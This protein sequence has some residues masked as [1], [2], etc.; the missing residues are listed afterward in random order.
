[1]SLSSKGFQEPT[2][3]V[4]P[5]TSPRSEGLNKSQVADAQVIEFSVIVPT[6]NE[7]GNI[8]ELVRLLHAALDGF[9]WE[10]VFVDDDSP[11]KTAE[12]VKAIGQGD[13]HVRCI[14]RIGRRGLAGACIE[15]ILSSTAP[16]CAVMDADL[17]H[18][19]TLLPK[20]L[21]MIHEGADV[22]IGSR[23][24]E[25]GT[26]GDGFAIIRGWGSKFSTWLSRTLLRVNVTDPMSGFFAVR[27]DPFEKSAESLS[28]DGFKILLDYLASGQPGLVVQE[29]P[30]SFRS[31]FS[32][33]SK[34][35]TSVT[36][37]FL[38]LLVS[39]LTN[40]LLNIRF[41][42]FSLIGVSGVV[43]HLATQKTI[44]PFASFPIAQAT[45]SLV[46]MFS[47]FTLNNV[48]T[49]RDK[50]LRGFAFFRGFL[51]FVLVCG[52][53]V[54]GSVGVGTWVNSPHEHWR[55]AWWISGLAGALIG[56]LWNYS[57]SSHVTWKR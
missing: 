46:A 52:V 11:D 18:D 37:E 48:I 47:N 38:N 15:G 43:V 50:R 25:G 9:A 29:L 45:G 8:T 19:E 53:G 21:R 49:F 10:V 17:Q 26:A 6:F 36:L 5:K 22:V 28:P 39:R 30:F 42:L 54:I 40:G 16:V 1:V 20:M 7:A 35:D 51:S 32:G 31:R 14:H 2:A 34:L 13:P 57:I 24:I 12:I 44:L 4:T 33:E 23:Y 56:G 3:E 27:R 41:I 55:V